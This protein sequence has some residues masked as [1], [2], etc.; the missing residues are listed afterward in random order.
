MVKISRILKFSSWR[1]FDEFHWND[2]CSKMTVK[3]PEQ[4]WDFEQVLL[5]DFRSLL[6][7]NTLRK[8]QKTS[9][10]VT[11]VFMRVWKSNIGRK[12]RNG[13]K[14]RTKKIFQNLMIK[15]R[16]FFLLSSEFENI[17][18][19]K[20]VFSLPAYTLSVKKIWCSK[21]RWMKVVNYVN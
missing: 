11:L 14:L 4:I 20:N 2:L 10:V 15:A 16:L 6:P 3:L 9:G 13:L 7:F 18:C 5:I 17:C 8:H 12:G 1:E 21:K 19:W